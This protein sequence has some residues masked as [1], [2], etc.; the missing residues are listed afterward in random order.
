M[1]IVRIKLVPR[2]SHVFHSSIDQFLTLF[3][4]KKSLIFFDK[5]A[6]GNNCKNK[7]TNQKTLE[8]SNLG[9]TT[10]CLYNVR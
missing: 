4:G 7:K 10:S 3:I 6:N 1:M 2:H 5:S 9:P 8:F